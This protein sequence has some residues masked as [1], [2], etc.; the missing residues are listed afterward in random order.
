[1][2]CFR[3]HISY[4]YPDITEEVQ[5]MHSRLWEVPMA[6]KCD[7]EKVFKVLQIILSDS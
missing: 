7:R 2:A 5:K 1:M 4:T 6:Y 3:F